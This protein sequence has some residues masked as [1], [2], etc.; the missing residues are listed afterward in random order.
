MAAARPPVA[1]VALIAFVVHAFLLAAGAAPPQLA[2]ESASCAAVSTSSHRFG[3]GHRGGFPE[4]S[5]GASALVQSSVRTSA[6]SRLGSVSEPVE[7]AEASSA[8]PEAE[9]EGEGSSAVAAAPAAASARSPLWK[10]VSDSPV[11]AAVVTD[12]DSHDVYLP[13]PLYSHTKGP[14][15]ALDGAIARALGTDLLGD[16]LEP[17]K[18]GHVLEHPAGA[19]ADLGHGHEEHVSHGYIAILF[20][21]GSLAIGSSLLIVLERHVATIPYTCALFIAGVFVSIIHY[22]KSESNPLHWPTWFISVSM[23]DNINPHLIFYAFLP[24]LIFGEAMRLNVQLV[25]KCF[26][27]VFLLA[28]PG[29]VMGTLL[30]AWF[31]KNVLPYGWD[32]PIALVFGSI[33]S[34]T[35]PVAV[36]ALFNTLGVSPRLTMIISGESLLNDGT[37]I[38]IFALM[39]KTAMGASIPGAGVMIFFGHMTVTAVFLGLAMGILSVIIIGLCAEEHYHSDAMIQVV[40]TIFCGYLAFFLAESEI[41]TS[42]VITTVTAGFVIAY[43]AHPRFVSRET[44][45][46]VWETIEFVGN[47]VI[48][49]LAGLIFTN[50]V[51]A[52]WSFIGLADVG[53]LFVLYFALMVI[54]ALMVLFF[55]VP[56][57]LVGSPLNWKEGLVMVWSGLRG[58]V[59]LAL[60]IIVDIEPGI[61]KQ[62]GSR[63]MFHVGG[64]AALTFII[65]ATTSAKLLSLL[66]LTKTSHARERMLSQF[67]LHT[68]ELIARVFEEDLESPDDIR[69]KGANRAIVRGMV[70]GLRPM[71]SPPVEI[72]NP[73]EE[74]EHQLLRI[75][76]EAFLRVVQNHY[77]AGIEEGVIP[78]NLKAAR[79]LLHSTDEA[80]DNSWL[81]INDWDVISRDINMNQPN[82]L[83]KFLGD[84]VDHRPFRWVAEFRRTFSNEFRTMRKVYVALCYQEA[85]L[86][87]RAEVPT[88]FGADSELDKR[89]QQK[90]AQESTEQCKQAAELLEVV[91][92]ESV[93][94][95]KSEMLARKLLHLQ[96]ERVT[97]ML[98][99]GLFTNSEA[100]HLEHQVTQAVR[101]I[102]N[103]PKDT[104]LAVKYSKQLGR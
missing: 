60:A 92:A 47:T 51:L 84:V 23:W 96:M 42:G 101:D 17:T 13:V 33:L 67:Q 81:C 25:A 38:V 100:N 28:C 94:L 14:D 20:F 15:E 57:N 61:D 44:F 19:S 72:T 35:D 80:L 18:G 82:S 45:T 48:F 5:S 59:S 62:M 93:E 2:E 36:V 86:R 50:N 30:T 26:W 104:W 31:G 6:A 3:G 74:E 41:H 7:A 77:W 40:V 89:V 95:G 16:S 103:L 63:V 37:A 71:S 64:V 34:A 73:S 29:V 10:P 22:F 43:S 46:I 90:V 102:V 75:Y 24:A 79:I 99:K 55:W 68:A 65:N 78:R 8:A 69:F 54:R 39:L 66:G 97:H 87:A 21:F 52:R 1:L 9:Q 91:P 85:H 11:G 12:K 98:D 53:W 49:F 58:A 70:P 27:Q 56:L 4:A 83:M 88:F 76:R 32:W